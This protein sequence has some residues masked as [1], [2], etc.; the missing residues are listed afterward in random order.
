MFNKKVD[1]LE[2][3][4]V[5]YCDYCGVVIKREFAQEVKIKGHGYHYCSIHKKP[6]EN[7]VVELE[8]V[9]SGIDKGKWTG[10]E[11]YRYFTK[12]EVDVNGKPIKK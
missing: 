12:I 10:R 7:V 11:L 9:K 4:E 2:K 5:V 8:T 6:Y 1:Y 3:D